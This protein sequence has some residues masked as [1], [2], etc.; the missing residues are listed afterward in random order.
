MAMTGTG[1]GALPEPVGPPQIDVD[2][3]GRH[4]LRI[5]MRGRPGNPITAE[6]ACALSN[7]VDAAEAAPDIATLV[8]TSGS[9]AFCVGADLGDPTEPGWSIDPTPARDLFERLDRTTLTTIAVVDGAAIGGGV[10]LA[11]ACDQVIAGPRAS[12]R[13]TEVLL[14]LVPAQVLP[15]IAE[16]VGPRRAHMLAMTAA[17]VGPDEAIRLGLADY[18]TDAPARDLQRVL[19]GLG[20]VDPAVLRSLKRYH[21]ACRPSPDTRG[22]LIAE[23]QQERLRDPR[24]RERLNRLVREGLIR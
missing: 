24:T 10:G 16:R 13:L 11:A 19:R 3:P 8:L 9:D 6:L 22:A 1:P 5:T 23:V 21:N 7:A 18:A 4:V 15:I 17:Q 12:F 2:E 20:R 14:G